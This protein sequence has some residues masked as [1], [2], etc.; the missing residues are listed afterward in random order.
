MSR[1]SLKSKLWQVYQSALLLQ[2]RAGKNSNLHCCNLFRIFHLSHT[3]DIMSE[4]YLAHTYIL[5]HHQQQTAL[6]GYIALLV[7]L[8]VLLYLQLLLKSK[9]LQ[10]LRHWQN[11]THPAM[12]CGRRRHLPP[13]FLD[14]PQCWPQKRMAEPQRTTPTPTAYNTYAPRQAAPKCSN[15]HAAVCPTAAA[16]SANGVGWPQQGTV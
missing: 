13:F 1:T 5:F 6:R 4:L 12:L 8:R 15:A 7:M 16:H 10:R 2:L 9:S 11:T 3:W 14:S